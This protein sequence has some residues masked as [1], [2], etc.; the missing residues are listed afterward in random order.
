VLD[1]GLL[2]S[3]GLADAAHRALVAT[4]VLQIAEL[5]AAWPRRRSRCILEVKEI[6][7]RR[8]AGLSFPSL[9]DLH[10]GFLEDLRAECLERCR[11]ATGVDRAEPLVVRW[12]PKKVAKGGGS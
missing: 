2:R 12:A 4:G 7:V 9:D 10:D 6:T 8:P 5:I 3:Y 1:L 11:E